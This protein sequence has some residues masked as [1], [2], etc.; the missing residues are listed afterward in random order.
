MMPLKTLMVAT[1]AATLLSATPTPAHAQSQQPTVTQF[2]DATIARLLLEVQA[3]F[4]IEAGP[5][6]EKVYRASAE[7]GIAFTLS[8]RECG[9]E[10]GCSGLLLV[11]VFT[12]S[13]ASRLGELD[14][15][16]HRYN[17]LNPGGK[18]Y[19][20]D[21]GAV[22]LQAYITALH[23]ISYPN[24]RAQLLRFGDEIVKVR[25]TLNAFS[26]GR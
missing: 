23:G 9:A 18:V 11:A 5:Q 16:L 13:D 26:A 10:T 21:D 20:T 3:N 1:L 2:N 19:R 15:L 6:G 14:R 25:E 4:N 17:D 24:A 7:G 8:A 12:G 22:V